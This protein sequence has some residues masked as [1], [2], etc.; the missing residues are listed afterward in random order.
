MKVI[1]LVYSGNRLEAVNVTAKRFSWNDKTC[2]RVH[3][4]Y[5]HRF[6]AGFFVV[7]VY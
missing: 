2:Q 7:K 3:S 6:A 5:V 4:D 1:G